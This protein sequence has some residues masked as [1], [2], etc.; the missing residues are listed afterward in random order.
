MNNSAE[1]DLLR[2]FEIKDETH[3]HTHDIHIQI[4]KMLRKCHQLFDPF[5]QLIMK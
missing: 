3:T 1:M 5:A 2:G 4:M